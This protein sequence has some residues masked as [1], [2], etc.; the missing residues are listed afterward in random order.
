MTQQS[1][2]ELLACIMQAVTENNAG[3]FDRLF[4]FLM[5]ERLHA[6]GS[7]T[8]PLVKEV[9]A[10]TGRARTTVLAVRYYQLLRKKLI[11]SLE[12]TTGCRVRRRMKFRL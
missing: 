7:F 9:F 10:E 5:S 1:K 12:L 8:L 11:T 6:D 4:A 2:D 3:W